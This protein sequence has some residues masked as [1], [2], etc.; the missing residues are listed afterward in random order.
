MA[1]QIRRRAT[2]EGE[3]VINGTIVQ[4]YRAELS[5]DNPENLILSDW[6][7]DQATYKAN[8]AEVRADL[9]EFEDMVFALQDELIAAKENEE[10]GTEEAGV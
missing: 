8:R 5:E 1:L 3:S 7:V 6:I 9:H 4:G 2:I 10:A